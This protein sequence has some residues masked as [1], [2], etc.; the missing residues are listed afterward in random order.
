MGNRAVITTRENFE[1]NGIGVYLQWNGGRDSVSAFLEYCRL[2]NFR[3]PEED[4]YGWA[5]LIQIIANFICG[6]LSLGADT[7][8]HLD[9]D[10]KDNGTYIIEKWRIVGREYFDLEEQELYP[11]KD[12]L[13]AIDRRQPA[14]QQLGHEYLVASEDKPV[15]QIRMGDWVWVPNI[16]D[17]CGFEKGLVTGRGN[18]PDY[19][20]D[21]HSDRIVPYVRLL[22]RSCYLTETMYR[23]K[24]RRQINI[25]S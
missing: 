5:R 6:G 1:N 15:E 7:V 8:D 22:G 19:Y 2:R 9:L 23:V 10:N 4:N 14:E 18:P 24:I 3:P 11:L 20:G 25:R 13:M 21:A 16:D 17:D 12:M